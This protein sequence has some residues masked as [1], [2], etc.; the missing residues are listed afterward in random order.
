MFDFENVYF[1][2]GVLS[3][4]PERK[5]VTTKCYKRLTVNLPGN[6]FESHGVSQQEGYCCE[7]RLEIHKQTS[8]RNQ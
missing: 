7:F 4:F 1:C 5:D 3:F 6:W 8:P 2:R